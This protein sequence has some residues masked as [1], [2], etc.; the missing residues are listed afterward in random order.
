MNT[1]AEIMDGASVVN[2]DTGRSDEGPPFCEHCGHFHD[3]DGLHLASPC[4]D[5]RCCIQLTPFP[6]HAPRT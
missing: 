5:R 2:L 6:Q 4:P 1:V 3:P